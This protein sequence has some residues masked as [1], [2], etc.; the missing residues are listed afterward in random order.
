MHSLRPKCPFLL[1][2]ILLLCATILAALCLRITKKR[3][4]VQSSSPSTFPPL[5]LCSLA[6]E[7]PSGDKN[8]FPTT[9]IAFRR[10]CPIP[11]NNIPALGSKSHTH[12]QKNYYLTCFTPKKQ[13]LRPCLDV[14]A[15]FFLPER[16]TS[17]PSPP[18]WFY[19][20]E[21]WQ[22]NISIL[23]AISSARVQTLS[24]VSVPGLGIRECWRVSSGSKCYMMSVMTLYIIIRSHLWI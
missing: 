11:V 24:T 13:L 12:T 19:D 9:L 16:D 21:C 18:G 8:H 2:L 15:G 20:N 10:H 4:I 3:R 23:L 1:E 14:V 22:L 17:S 6:V 7:L 5:R